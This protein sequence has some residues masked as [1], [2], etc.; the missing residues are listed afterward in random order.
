MI[1]IPKDEMTPKERMDAFKWRIESVI[2]KSSSNFGN[3]PSSCRNGSKLNEVK[4]ES[5]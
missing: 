1:V 5:I 2:T 4:Y 3:T